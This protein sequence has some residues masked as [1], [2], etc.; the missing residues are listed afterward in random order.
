MRIARYSP[1]ANYVPGKYMLVSDALSRS[2]F[3]RIGPEKSF[4]EEINIH[5]IEMLNNINISGGKLK[6][7]T[8]KQN[9]DAT[10]RKFIAIFYFVRLL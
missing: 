8:R 7:I 4:N 3:P 6:Q 9:N 5:V 10:I 2:D 1:T